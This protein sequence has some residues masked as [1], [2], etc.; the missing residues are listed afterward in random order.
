MEQQGSVLVL[1]LLLH[2]GGRNDQLQE[3]FLSLESFLMQPFPLLLFFLLLLGLLLLF[4]LLLLGLLLL[5]LLL[6]RL[7]L[8]PLLLLL[9]HSLSMYLGL[10]DE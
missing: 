10:C 1:L 6:Q 9:R 8:P 4:F 7:L 2:Q 3:S 5:A